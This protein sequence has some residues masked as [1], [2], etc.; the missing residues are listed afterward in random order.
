LFLVDRVI[1]GEKEW[2][3]ERERL[4]RNG[5]LEAR[6]TIRSRIRAMNLQCNVFVKLFVP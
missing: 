1:A 3:R 5:R 2:E 4:H 6:P